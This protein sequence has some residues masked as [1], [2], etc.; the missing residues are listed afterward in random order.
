MTVN[1]LSILKTLICFSLFLTF[2]SVPSV[3]FPYAV[4]VLLAASTILLMLLNREY[5]VN[6]KMLQ[7][8]SIV[9]V[10]LTVSMFLTGSSFGDYK[11]LFIRL[12]LVLLII[13][14]FGNNYKE[15]TRGIVNALWIIVVLA[16]LNFLLTMIVPEAFSMLQNDNGYQVYSLGYLFNMVGGQSI[17]NIEI[18]RNQSFFWEPGVLQIPINV[19]IYYIL[20]EKGEPVRKA[21]LPIFILLTTVS[22]TGYILLLFI[23]FMKFKNSF[24]LRGKGLIKSIGMALVVVAFLPIL[25][26]EI[27]SKFQGD[28]KA[29]STLRTFDLLIGLKVAAD[30]PLT[31][32]GMNSDKMLEMTGLENVEIEGEVVSNERGN[33]NS[34]I[35]LAAKLGFPVTIAVLI[36]LYYQR[37]FHHRLVFFVIIVLSLASEPLFVTHFVFLFLMSAVK[38]PLST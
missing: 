28:A 8:V 24:S 6:K 12:A 30:Y 19:L 3:F 32:I 27:M 14:A 7:V 33:T 15:I 34:F 22:T 26:G 5:R 31:G 37:L 25:Y 10:I 16:S 38:L 23:L 18:I 21:I 20:I 13:T 4:E 2:G 29:S 1:P 9:F 35:A 11:I 36:A 17:L